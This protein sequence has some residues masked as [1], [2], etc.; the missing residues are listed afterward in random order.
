M[1]GRGLDFV[2]QDSHSSPGP[3]RP[4]RSV[5][6]LTHKL[7]LLQRSAGNQA[8]AALIL[9]R[10]PAAPAPAA[11]TA[12]AAPTPA[13][14]AQQQLS[15]A[16]IDKAVADALAAE[17]TAFQNISVTINGPTAAANK[18]IT[19]RAAYYINQGNQPNV[20]AAR[21]SG[22][23]ETIRRTLQSQS[24]VTT[25]GTAYHTGRAV[26]LGKSTPDDVAK[27]VEA[28]QAQILTYAVGKGAKK[29]DGHAIAATDHLTDL[30]SAVLQTTVQ[31]WVHDNG[32]GV[33]CS[34]FVLQATI[35]AREAVR[36]KAQS[37]NAV[38]PPE[39]SHEERSA[40]SF[41]SGTAR[42]APTDLRVGDVWVI[43]TPGHHVRIV[44]AVRDAKTATHTDCIEFDTAES[45]G[46]VDATTVGPTSGTYQ[47]ASKTAFDPLTPSGHGDGAG[48]FYPM[49]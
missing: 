25:S 18:T 38:V 14:P 33:D 26:E 6:P 16:E 10:T 5:P 21:T 20:S 22:Q 15:Q 17:L 42:A 8:V 19:I 39:L 31:N 40:S 28:A 27:F 12:A 35:K 48:N 23:F 44:T 46:D 47:T 34:G 36:A 32:V 43:G 3:S 11:A 49:N 30:D 41:R 45:S 4:A 7:L 1:A 24:M 13:P 37:Q 29:P 9:Q 2:N